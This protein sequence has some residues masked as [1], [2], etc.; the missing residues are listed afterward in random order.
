[1]S[2]DVNKALVVASI[3]EGCNTRRLSIFDELFAPDLVDHGVPAGLPK[4]LESRKQMATLYWSAFPD[5]RLTIED[6]IAEGE[7]VVTRWTARGTN[8]GELMGTPPTGQRVVVTGISIHRFV[9]GKI[10]ESW[11]E[12]D[13]DN[14]YLRT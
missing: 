10:V 13:R 4:T 11:A 9:E 8:M 7:K 2:T 5:L 1:M 6:Q 12:I 14:L 3:E